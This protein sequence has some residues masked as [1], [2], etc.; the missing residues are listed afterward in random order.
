MVVHR[1][2][3]GGWRT[4]AGGRR[5]WDVRYD[6]LVPGRHD[7]A[8][9]RTPNAHTVSRV[10]RRLAVILSVTVLVATSV[11]GAVAIVHSRRVTWARTEAILRIDQLVAAG[12][13]AAAVALV[14]QAERHAPGNADLMARWPQISAVGSIITTPEGATVFMRDYASSSAA[15]WTYIGETPLRDLRLPRGVLHFKIA[16]VGFETLNLMARNRGSLLQNQGATAISL[17]KSGTVPPGMVSVPGGSFPVSLIGFS[18]D[19]LVDIDPFVIDR[20]EVTNEEFRRFIE[21]GGYADERWWVAL[22]FIDHEHQ[23]TRAEAVSRFID[24]TSAPGPAGWPRGGYPAGQADYPVGGVSW[25]EAAAYCR[26]VG[27]AL[28][29]LFHWARAAVSPFE[30]QS[31]LAPSIGALSNFSR[32]ETAPV[33]AFRGMGPYGTLD[34]AGNVREWAWNESQ[35]ERRWILGGAWTDATSSFTMP[36][37]LLPFDRSLTNGFRCAQPKL[38]AA[39]WLAGMTPLPVN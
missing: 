13:P 2:P 29:T 15:D 22:P 24:A 5:P 30:A 7:Q 34:M 4:D 3:V 1:S 38:G 33:G 27:K 21:S 8:D 19:H 25:Y 36:K 39:P 20:H 18:Q 6:P 37:S 14:E 31:P 35:P 12:R 10:L 28:P 26:F 23:L 16:K 32:E 17:L 9:V 11:F